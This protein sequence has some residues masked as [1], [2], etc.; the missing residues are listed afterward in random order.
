MIRLF[1][2]ILLIIAHVFSGTAQFGLQSIAGY[3]IFE[4]SKIQNALAPTNSMHY[5]IGPSYWFRLKN[6][7]IEFNPA[8]VFDYNKSDFPKNDINASTLS[9]YNIALTLPILIYPLDFSNDCNCPTFNKSGQFFEKGF[10]FL[11]YGALPYS[12]KKIEGMD[13]SFSKS[14]TSVQ[15]GIGAGVDIG[16]NKKWTLS[17]S[18]MISKLFLDR[19]LLD[20]DQKNILDLENNRYRIDL[21]IRLLWF[22]KKRR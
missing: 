7:R 8:I 20:T 3:N 18:V 15:L 13:I 12:S 11:I 1:F 10:Y 6:K 21:M 17:P 4:E 14:Y 16:L 22:T 2:S 19:N 5:L 9:E